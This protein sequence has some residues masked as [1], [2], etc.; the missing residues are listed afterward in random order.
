METQN[1]MKIYIIEDDKV[2]RTELMKLLCSYGYRCDYSEDWQNIIQLFF[3]SLSG[4]LIKIM[5]R[6][7]R[8][9]FKQLNMFV[10]RQFPARLIR[11]LY[12]F[13][14]SALSCYSSSESFLPGTVCR[15]FYQ[16]SC[17]QKY[18]MSIVLQ[19]IIMANRIR[20]QATASESRAVA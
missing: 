3:W 5:Q 2:L 7:K 19:T 11:I 1:S 10:V 13:L 17:V 15:T 4:I 20:F 18:R 12:R 9:Y 16:R 14:L 8:L 6:N